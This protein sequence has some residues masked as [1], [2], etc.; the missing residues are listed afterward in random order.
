MT[1]VCNITA[2]DQDDVRCDL[3]DLF[4]PTEIMMLMV[5]LSKNSNK[6]AYY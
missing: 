5:A 4:P 1:I 2:I 3:N 6:D